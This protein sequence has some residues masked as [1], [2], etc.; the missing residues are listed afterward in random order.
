M[1]RISAVHW[2][3]LPALVLCLILGAGC[4]KSSRA[5]DLLADANRDFQATNYDKAEFEYESVLRL[6]RGNPVAVRQLGFIYFEEGRTLMVPYLK[7]A[8]IQNPSNTEVQ[9][10]MA[11]IYGSFRDPTN[12]SKSLNLLESVLHADPGNEQAL[13]LLAEMAPTNEVS[14][15]VQR[16]E[17]QIREGGKG[18]AACRAALGWIDLRMTN[19]ADAAREFQ[20]ASALDPKLASPYLGQANLCLLK[21]NTIGYGEAL[22]TAAELSPIRSS[23]RI[24]YAEFKLKIGAEEVAKEVSRDSTQTNAWATNAKVLES[25]E[26]VRDITGKAPDYI[27]A[28]LWQMNLAFEE[29]DYRECKTNIDKILARDN[30][31]LEAMLKLGQVAMA[32]RDRPKAVSVLQ[33]LNDVYQTAPEVKY[34]L[35]QAYLMNNEKQKA[36]ASLNEALALKPNYSPAVLKLADLDYGLGNVSDAV[37]RLLNL[38]KNHPEDTQA[39]LKLAEIYL[40]LKQPAR[41]LAVYQ[42][43]DNQLDKMFG[44]NGETPEAKGLHAEILRLMGVAYY[45]QGDSPKALESFENSL[46]HEATYLPA[47]QEIASLDILEKNYGKA[48][49]RMDRAMD[50]DPKEKERSIWQ[51]HIYRLQG[52]IY[53]N[54]G[55]TKEAEAAYCKA[56]DLNPD[57]SVAYWNLAELYQHSGQDQ[58]ALDRLNALLAKS[59]N[60]VKNTNERRSLVKT[61]MTIGE[62]HQAARRYGQAS[63]A[64]EKILAVNPNSLAALNN[65]AYVDSEYLNKVDDALQLATRARKINPTDPHL[66]DTMG[67][68]LYKKHEYDLALTAIQESADKQPGDPEVEMHLGM[69]HYML[70]EEKPARLYLQQALSSKADFPDKELAQ[71]CLDIL[72]ID[73]GKATQEQVQ[74]LQKLVKENAQDPVPLSHLAAIQEQ[75]GKAQEAADSLQALLKINPNDSSA[76]IRLA[77]LY[78]NQLNDPRQALEL[79]KKAHGLASDDASASALLGELVYQRGD[80]AWALSLLQDAAPRVS[81][82]PSFFYHLALAYYAMG[83]TTEA[84]KAMTK[85]VQQGDSPANLEQAEQFQAMRAAVKDPVLAQAS[86][87]QVQE[88]LAKDPNYVP[89]LMVSAL[90]DERGGAPDK[91]VQTYQKVLTLYSA[92]TPGMRE[93]AIL[94]SRSKNQG[95]LDKAY[96][97]AE[98]ARAALPDDLELARVL[99]VLACNRGECQESILLLKEYTDKFSDDGEA[100]CYLGMDYYTNKQQDLCKPALEHALNL[101]IAEPLNGQARAILK[102]LNESP[103]VAPRTSAKPPTLP[104]SDTPQAQEKT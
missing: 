28:W 59:T 53:Q 63:E 8:L 74:K 11:E 2:A 18:A 77:R 37:T 1:K 13:T 39:Q 90:L 84:D 35:A 27:P 93:L 54:E 97:L 32:E 55:N 57:L 91:A 49:E 5:K 69:A 21:T 25:K 100:F 68:I 96:N 58:Q 45:T 104:V 15:V 33:H 12:I 22:K 61:L 31:N 40:A 66:A 99:G 24:K 76:M 46:K 43:L 47:L 98:G 65:L 7:Q 85:A 71:R 44:E 20:Q 82:Q 48:H 79:A 26:I 103:P 89:A 38:T 70:G 75:Q 102:K 73:P 23:T 64:Y 29:G 3:I 80:Y 4:S 9:L 78:A 34:Y 95:D 86:S 62:I 87:A 81:D 10:K 94:Y 30:L 72:D 17:T 92:F 60:D 6:T 36:L 101:N 67:W 51:G 50:Q 56:I 16:L 41:A 83:R 19:F 42:Y 14:N 52:D 88:I